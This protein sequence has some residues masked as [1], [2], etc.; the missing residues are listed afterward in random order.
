[1][2]NWGRDVYPNTSSDF[3]S[4][5]AGTS[6]PELIVAMA[7][8]FVILTAA[9]ELLSSLQHR[10]TNQQ[11]SLAQ[12]QDVRLSL[13]LLSE[14]LHLAAPDSLF[15]MK[16]DEVE[17]EANINGIFSTV[18][19]PVLLGQTEIKVLDGRDWPERKIILICWN[20]RCETMT[21]ARDGQ[22]SVLTVTQPVLTAIPSGAF[23]TIR[24][25]VRYYT[26]RDENGSLR[27]LR[28]VDGGASVLVGDIQEMR[29]SYW[30]GQG[31]QETQ[32][33]F[34]RRI[35]VEL[36]L[37]GRSTRAVREISLRD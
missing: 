8:G 33:P 16:Q 7:V 30:N 14:E 28:Q 9:V 11:V 12:Q 25:R 26:R 36:T 32:A 27:L 17:F 1:M 5:E 15:V 19:A 37:A 29:L 3:P 22:R 34:V 18:S 10:F 13:E 2:T 23:V 21:L 6:L 31:R 4:D 24:N 35:V 20:D